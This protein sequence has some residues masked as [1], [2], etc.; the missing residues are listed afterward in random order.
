MDGIHVACEGRISQPDDLKYTP[1]GT[2]ALS[3]GLVVTDKKGIATWLRVT[4]WKERAEQ[5]AEILK[6]GDEVYIE[7]ALTAS[8]WETATG[9]KRHGLNVS[10]WKCEPLGQ[11]GCKRPTRPSPPADQLRGRWPGAA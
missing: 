2:A 9:E 7:G 3:F 5:L 1:S 8:E 10:T 6:K 11:I 4:V